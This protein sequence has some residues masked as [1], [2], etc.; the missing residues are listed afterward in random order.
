MV[1]CK[2]HNTRMFLHSTLLSF[3]PVKFVQIFPALSLQRE[4]DGY[5]C[6]EC[7]VLTLAFKPV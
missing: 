6:Y 4:M 3:V 7:R 1:M 2:L 5:F